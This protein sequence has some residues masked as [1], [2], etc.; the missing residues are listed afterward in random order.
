MGLQFAMV[1]IAGFTLMAVVA[2]LYTTDRNKVEVP[3]WHE[4][5]AQ[6]SLTRPALTCLEY[7]KVQGLNYEPYHACID[8]AMGQ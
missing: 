6:C 4:R 3:R 2:I 7:C 8:G 1:V 5:G